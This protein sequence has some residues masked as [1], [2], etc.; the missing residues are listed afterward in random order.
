[1]NICL[2]GDA[3][4]I[5]IKRL[6]SS[7]VA[8]GHSVHVVTHKPVDIPGAIVERFAVPAPGLTNPRGWESRRT[9]YLQKILRR[10]DVTNVHFLADWGLTPEIMKAGPVIATAWG[11]DIVP[12]PGEGMPLPELTSARVS[13]LRHAQAVTTCGPTFAET[14]ARYAELE[15]DRIN[16]VPFG[17]DVAQFD[18]PKRRSDEL[19]RV[20]FF[21]G[22]R[23]V[24]GATDLIRAIPLVLERVPNVRFELIGDG[25][26]LTECQNIATRMGLNQCIEWISRQ[27][28]SDIPGYLSRWDL[29]V[30]PSVCEAFGVAALES[31][32]AGVP[33]VASDICGLRDTVLDGRTGLL[34]Q[35]HSPKGIAEA[36]TTLL[37]DDLQRAKMG[38]VGAGWVKTVFDQRRVM[39]K[40]VALYERVREQS[41]VMI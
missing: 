36:L 29:T 4:S 25:A 7:L 32:A 33:V 34:V 19:L 23:E 5:H 22:F 40:W 37:L 17:V 21:K 3:R 12:P 24:Y 38:T 28:H 10:H 2:L 14:V 13:L 15:R 16:V 39:E 41:V 18:N 20:G 31:S 30:I 26:Q 11:S 9:H 27:A 6:A 8:S 1:L 35:P